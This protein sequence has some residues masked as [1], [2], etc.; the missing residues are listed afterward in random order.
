MH[1]SL[2]FSS[3]LIFSY[4]LPTLLWAQGISPT[5]QGVSIQL[6]GNDQPELSWDPVVGHGP[7]TGL[8]TN[9]TFDYAPYSDDY[10]IDQNNWQVGDPQ[11]G[12]QYVSG[13]HTLFNSSFGVD[14]IFFNPGSGPNGDVNVFRLEA[15]GHTPFPYWPSPVGGTSGQKAKFDQLHY[16]DAQGSETDMIDLSPLGVTH[17]EQLI[18][19]P[20][21][22]NY[23]YSYL[24][25]DDNDGDMDEV[26]AA[27]LIRADRIF[28]TFDLE[29]HI[30]Y[31][32]GQTT[33][34]VYRRVAGGGN[35]A[36]IANGITD[37]SY[38]DTDPL[39]AGVTY[40][41]YLTAEMMY[42]ESDPSDAV[43]LTTT[44]AGPGAL[45]VEWLSFETSVTGPRQVRL[46][47]VTARERDNLGFA[48][49]RSLDGETFEKVGEVSAVGQSSTPQRY[50]FTDRRAPQ[51]QLYYR[52]RQTDLD[53]TVTYSELR[54]VRAE[55]FRS[56]TVRL[57]PNPAH[58]VVHISGL[59][60]DHQH[61]VRLVDLQGN[62][63][64]Q[65]NRY[66][67]PDGRLSLPLR[68]LS[69]GL[70][71]VIVDDRENSYQASLSVVH[72]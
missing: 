39:Q 34:R 50:D 69:Q 57:Y 58:H 6:N 35:W 11:E 30:V 14:A 23:Q 71:R 49:E 29:K 4:L 46:T 45:P 66:P 67:R 52:L 15:F 19:I 5:P 20:G 44:D 41:Y 64:A 63:L 54:E 18:W 42:G 43:S 28:G 31:A 32:E 3:L 51:R 72:R 16:F 60:P 40:E 47:W 55:A 38:T 53:G 12:R 9:S 59:L 10:G 37:L 27:I 25:I 26:A 61:R 56:P 21:T 48:I 24:M 7:Q 8:I 1:T 2:R 68:T 62:V 65:F 70:Y 33:Y 17:P 36:Q 13:Q 22:G